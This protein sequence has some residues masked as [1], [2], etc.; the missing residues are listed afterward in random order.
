MALVTASTTKFKTDQTREDQKQRAKTLCVY[1]DLGAR[2]GRLSAD[3]GRQI[4]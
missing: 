4:E 1:G 2:T 3:Y